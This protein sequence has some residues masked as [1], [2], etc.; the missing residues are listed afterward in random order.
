MQKQIDSLTNRLLPTVSP[1]KIEE[2]LVKMREISSS[3]T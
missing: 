3:K 2:M 1:H